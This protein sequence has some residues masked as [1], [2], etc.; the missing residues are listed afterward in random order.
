MSATKRATLA[1]TELALA[2]GGGDVQMSVSIVINADGA[3]PV[4]ASGEGGKSNPSLWASYTA[5]TTV[6]RDADRA[7]QG[8]QPWTGP[9][10]SAGAR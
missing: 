5:P 7:K 9:A 10:Q 2:L 8:A 3:S 4:R 6:L 1:S